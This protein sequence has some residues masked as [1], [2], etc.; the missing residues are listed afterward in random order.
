MVGQWSTSTAMQARAAAGAFEQAFAMTVP[1]PLIAANRAQ[2]MALIATNFFGQNT[3]AI[4][5]TE[6]QYAEMWAQDASA[7]FG[8]SASSAAAAQLAPFSSPQQTSNPA[9]LAAQSAA[10]TQA[11]ATPAASPLDNLAAMLEQYPFVAG[12][13]TS[14]S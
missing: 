2:L 11:A 5:A 12:I 3:A 7:M 10:V 14:L 9:G 4:A 1:P 6:A 8:Y 13:I